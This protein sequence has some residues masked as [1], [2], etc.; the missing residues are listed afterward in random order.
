MIHIM[1]EEGPNSSK[2]FHV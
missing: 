2:H 1:K